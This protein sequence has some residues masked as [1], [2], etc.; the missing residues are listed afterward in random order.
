MERSKFVVVVALALGLGS[1]LVALADGGDP[2]VIHACV[3]PSGLT[4]IVTPAESCRSNETP[5]H[6]AIGGATGPAA[7]T[8]DCGAEQTITDALQTAGVPLTITVIGT[9]VENVRISRDDVTLIGQP[10]ATVDGS[11][12]STVNTIT[13]LANR[14]VIDSLKVTGGRNGITAAG[15]ARL[16]V[17]NCTVQ[18]AGNNG[19]SFFQGSGTV[20]GCVIQQNTVANGVRVES[21]AVTVINSTI[22][23]NGGGVTVTNGGSARIGVT[24]TGSPGPNTIQG[25]VRGGVTVD[26]GASA[27][28]TGNTISGNGVTGGFSGGVA[29]TGGS[30]AQLSGNLITQNA[31]AGV[32][33]IAST[34]TIGASTGDTISANGPSGDGNQG[35][36]FAF[37]GSSVTIRNSQ[38]VQNTGRGV[39]LQGRSMGTISGGAIQNNTGFGIFLEFGAGLTLFG[40]PATITGNGGVDLQCSDAEASYVGFPPANLSGIGSISGSCTGF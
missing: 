32:L 18:N 30:T 12:A 17:R 23:G 34:I 1:P 15:A 38:I 3:N 22:A 9:C 28:V 26:L 33:V 35:G 6:W 13:V 10:G 2:S 29:V 5:V 20:D 40:S 19:I 37:L 25:N 27:I 21:G 39:W 16:M 4:R 36:V 8:V 31:G 14:V 24:D 11:A 7:V